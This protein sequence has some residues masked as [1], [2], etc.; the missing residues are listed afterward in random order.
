MDLASRCSACVQ[1]RSVVAKNWTGF[2]YSL[3]AIVAVDSVFL[4]RPKRTTYRLRLTDY[5]IRA[6]TRDQEKDGNAS[7]H[8]LYDRHRSDSV[9]WL[10]QGILKLVTTTP[11]QVCE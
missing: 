11:R 8:S 3:K 1:M 6:K 7:F 9:Y 5:D 4:T 2:P 10:W